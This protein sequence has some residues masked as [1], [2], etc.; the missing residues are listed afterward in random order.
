M[1]LLPCCPSII[2]TEISTFNADEIEVFLCVY[3]VSQHLPTADTVC[4]ALDSKQTHTLQHTQ[5][6]IWSCCAWWKVNSR[7]N[8]RRAIHHAALGSVINHR[9][10]YDLWVMQCE[11][12]LWMIS[13]SEP[14]QPEQLLSHLGHLGLSG[15]LLSQLPFSPPACSS[16]ALIYL[17]LY[18]RL[19]SLHCLTG[20][21]SSKCCIRSRA[22]VFSGMLHCA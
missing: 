22:A 12:P 6:R 17:R 14:K 4:A 21:W 8:T 7:A 10:G 15:L 11:W 18:F 5:C 13:K 1:M 2:L 3:V 9:R 16:L 20:T 19:F